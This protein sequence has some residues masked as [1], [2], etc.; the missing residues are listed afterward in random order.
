MIAAFAADY[1]TQVPLTRTASD[2]AAERTWWK[3]MTDLWIPGLG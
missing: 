3:R 1:R 2:E